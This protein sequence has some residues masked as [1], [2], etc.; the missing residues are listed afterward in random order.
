MSGL[1]NS[2]SIT[3]WQYLFYYELKVGMV[4]I[5]IMQEK[6]AIFDKIGLYPLAPPCAR[7]KEKRIVSSYSSFFRETFHDPILA[8]IPFNPNL[9]TP[10]L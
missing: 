8:V 4:S 3:W 5:I 1:A 9:A 10:S 2:Q 7:A 6:T